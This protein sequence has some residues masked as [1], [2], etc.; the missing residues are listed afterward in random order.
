MICNML[1]FLSRKT[2]VTSFCGI[3]LTENNWVN[4]EH[5]AE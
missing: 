4:P 3:F 1:K 5:S 2:D